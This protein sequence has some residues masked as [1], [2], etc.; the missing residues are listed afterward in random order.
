MFSGG[1]D[2]TSDGSNPN[3]SSY[4]WENKNNPASEL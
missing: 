4:I 1:V 3:F 2:V